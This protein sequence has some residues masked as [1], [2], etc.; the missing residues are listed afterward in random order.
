[1]RNAIPTCCVLRGVTV[2]RRDHVWSTDITDITDSTDSRLQ[3]GFLYLV[4]VLDWYSRYVLAWEL[5]NT[6]AAS[7]CLAALEAALAHGQPATQ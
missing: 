7:C 3:H 1:V 5:S 2:T 6:L 4:A